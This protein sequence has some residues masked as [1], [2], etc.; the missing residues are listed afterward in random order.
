MKDGDELVMVEIV[1]ETI[2][3]SLDV[4]ERKGR[5]VVIILRKGDI[6]RV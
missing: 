5:L 6:Y 3:C 2:K 1:K 4:C